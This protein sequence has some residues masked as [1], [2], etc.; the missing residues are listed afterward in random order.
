MKVA[1]KILALC[2][3]IV[4]LCGLSGKFEIKVLQ[5]GHNS[6]LFEFGSRNL[7][8]SREGV[9]INNFVVVTRNQSGNWD[10]ASPVWAFGLAPGSSKPLSEVVYAHVPDGF[11]ETT[12]ASELVPGVHYMAVGLSPGMGGSAEFIAN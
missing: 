5:Q 1:S 8:S 12:K 9:E 6:P 7:L 4:T 11:N 10:Y 2:V 3:I